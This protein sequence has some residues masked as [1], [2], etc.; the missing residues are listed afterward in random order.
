MRRLSQSLILQTEFFNQ[1]LTR[2]DPRELNLDVTIGLQA[3]KTNE[4]PGQIQNFDRLSHIEN[5]DLPTLTQYRSLQHELTGLG[6][7][8]EVA[9]DLRMRD[10]HRATSRNLFLEDGDNTAA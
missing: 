6:R 2:P 9:S 5:E 4:F 1:S 8:H 10:R 3:G 7:C